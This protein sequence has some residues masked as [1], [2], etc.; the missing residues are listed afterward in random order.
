MNALPRGA[1]VPHFWS[2][3]SIIVARARIKI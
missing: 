3:E 2:S 1:T